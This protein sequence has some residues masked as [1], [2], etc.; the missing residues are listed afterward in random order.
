M[1]VL[2][3]RRMGKNAKTKL[4]SSTYFHVF[5]KH[6]C[7]FNSLEFAKLAALQGLPL[8]PILFRSETTL[9]LPTYGNLVISHPSDSPV[10][11]PN[12]VRPV[13]LAILTRYTRKT[14]FSRNKLLLVPTTASGPAHTREAVQL[15]S[16]PAYSNTPFCVSIRE[17][18]QRRA[19]RNK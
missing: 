4:N 7:S 11:A 12:A 10:Q 6:V 19:N 15:A 5:S 18:L 1:L 8:P 16:G 13:A 17:Y 3:L 9:Q 2:I 14:R